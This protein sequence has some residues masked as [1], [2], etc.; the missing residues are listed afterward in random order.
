MSVERGAYTPIP[1]VGFAHVYR[2][3]RGPRVGGECAAHIYVDRCG[4]IRTYNKSCS[5]RELPLKNGLFG[6]LSGH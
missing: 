1:L 4:F 3:S 2:E 5:I 6:P